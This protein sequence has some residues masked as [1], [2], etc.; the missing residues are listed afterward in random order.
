MWHYY[1]HEQLNTLNIEKE[2]LNDES[3]KIIE[4]LNKQLNQH[5]FRCA[6]TTHQLFKNLA[7]HSRID[8]IYQELY[9]QNNND[10]LKL[11]GLKKLMQSAD[12]YFSVF[13]TNESIRQVIDRGDAAYN[14]PKHFLSDSQK[15]LFNKRNRRIAGKF[16][17]ELNS[18]QQDVS[19]FTLEQKL[20]RIKE[21][22]YDFSGL[23]SEGFGRLIAK[24]NLPLKDTLCSENLLPKLKEWDII[25]QKSPRKLTDFFIPGYFGHAGIYV[26][27][28]IFVQ[29]DQEGVHYDKAQ[30][31]LEG[32]DFIVLRARQLT[33]T[34]KKRMRTLLEAQLGKKYDFSFNT[35][36]PDRIICTELIFL[37][38]DQ[39][40]WNTR[41]TVFWSSISPDDLIRTSLRNEQ[42]K[43]PLL[44]TTSQMIENPD[45][46]IIADLLARKH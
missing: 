35:D 17:W 38:Y 24:I 25:C 39:I 15:F 21:A 12:F 11:Y 2:R 37:V 23:C 16:S 46:E 44:L 28:S 31:F 3:I 9:T 4:D 19:L 13:Q 43:I 42:F 29:C 1:T 8:C 22:A 45:K 36:S 14:I 26:G 27:D 33:P 32:N 30:E 34:Q 10:S 6:A 7:G 41:N 18:L 40:T 5:N 20:G